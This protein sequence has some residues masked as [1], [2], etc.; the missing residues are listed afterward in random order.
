M[1]E[2]RML[3]SE[4]VSENREDNRRV[5][6]VCNI[7]KFIIDNFDAGQRISAKE[8]RAQIPVD[9]KDPDLDSVGDRKAHGDAINTL[10]LGRIVKNGETLIDYSL[11]NLK[12]CASWILGEGQK[13]GA[14]KLI[15]EE[16]DVDEH[17]QKL[18]DD[19]AL[20]DQAMAIPLA[21]FTDW[22][23][24]F[25]F[26]LNKNWRARGLSEKQHKRLVRVISE[27][28]PKSE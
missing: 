2:S 27:R 21:N 26:S 11:P 23:R 20:I 7:A 25:V 14:V 19:N 18:N 22:E 16:T 10:N 6:R 4:Y 9:V 12:R 5:A 8:L 1:A 17:T 15:K 24:M 28:S 13:V 3:V